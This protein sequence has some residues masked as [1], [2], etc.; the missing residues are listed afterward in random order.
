M[1]S[2]EKFR[3]NFFRIIRVG[4]QMDFALRFSGNDGRIGVY[5]LSQDRTTIVY[6]DRSPTA[7]FSQWSPDGTAFVFSAYQKPVNEMSEKRPP[8]IFHF[9]LENGKLD[10]LTALENAVDRFPNWSPS[11]DMIAFHRQ[12]ME[13]FNK[14]TRVYLVDRNQGRVSALLPNANNSD[15]VDLPGRVTETGF[16]F[17]RTTTMGEPFAL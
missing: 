13:E 1:K 8:D 7:G 9:T 3:P 10:R 11:G 15:L 4:L 12:Y 14:P 5:D 2:L 6:E 16:H 17:T